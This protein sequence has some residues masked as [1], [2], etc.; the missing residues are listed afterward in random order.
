M[1]R[2]PVTLPRMLRP[3]AGLVYVRGSWWATYYQGGRVKRKSLG[4]DDLSLATER[5]DAWR[6]AQE[7]A[8]AS[9]SAR[10]QHVRRNAPATGVSRVRKPW[11]ARFAGRV[12]GTFATQAEAEAA[13]AAAAKGEGGA[14]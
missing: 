3:S 6:A 2:Q 12:L 8:G 1:N 13:V 14:P 5:R 9:V 4:T 11:R 7:A 10:K